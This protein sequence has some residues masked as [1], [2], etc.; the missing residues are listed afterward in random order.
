MK[1]NNAMFSY[2]AGFCTVLIFKVHGE[3]QLRFILLCSHLKLEQCGVVV[4]LPLRNRFLKTSDLI[5]LKRTILNTIE[6]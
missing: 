1:G 4:F 3:S 2:K 6:Q 5:F